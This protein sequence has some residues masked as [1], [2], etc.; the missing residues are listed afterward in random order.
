LSE[1]SLKRIYERTNKP[2]LSYAQ[3]EEKLQTQLNFGQKKKKN[4]Y[5]KNN[6]QTC[7]NA[8]GT[9]GKLKN[10]IVV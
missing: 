5:E 3:L 1:A 2:H 4:I 6:L 7:T 9:F 8:F 10:E